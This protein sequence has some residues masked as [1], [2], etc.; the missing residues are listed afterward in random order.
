[1]PPKSTI[2]QI[3]AKEKILMGAWKN[4]YKDLAF[5]LDHN[6][7][8]LEAQETWNGPVDTN[9]ILELIKS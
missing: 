6:F 9:K 1:M 7:V 2:V 3:T 5:A 4:C 8:S